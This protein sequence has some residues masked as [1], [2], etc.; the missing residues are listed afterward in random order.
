MAGGRLS[1][2]SCDLDSF[3]PP[4]IELLFNCISQMNNHVMNMPKKTKAATELKNRRR[5]VAALYLNKVD[6]TDIADKLGVSQSTISRDIK[7]LNEEWQAEAMQDVAKHV[8]R[9][10]AE[11]ERME[12]EV[13][14]MY[15]AAKKEKKREA[16]NWMET[17]L[18]IKDR[19][20][21]LIGLDKPAQLNMVSENKNINVKVS[22]LSDN[23]LME[24]INN[25][26]R[27][28]GGRGTSGKAAGKK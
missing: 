23:E 11:L 10:L 1:K 13:A 12:L 8:A 20:A 7:K 14:T 5:L 4:D 22:E 28:R 18:K 17:R 15:Q 6:Q 21:K 16:V 26:R 9:E 27:N 2:E 24:I 3:E 25:G 19:R